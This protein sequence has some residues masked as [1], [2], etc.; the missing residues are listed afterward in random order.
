MMRPMLALD[1]A[2][3]VDSDNET[4]VGSVAT[5]DSVAVAGSAAV[6]GSVAV[7]GSASTAGSVAVAGSVGTAGSV[8]VAGS[9]AT[10]GSVG[11]IASLFTVICVAVRE[12]VACLAMCRLHPVCRVHRVRALYG[13]RRVHRLRELFGTAECSG[14]KEYSR[15]AWRVN[16]RAGGAALWVVGVVGYL[17]LE[18]AAAAAYQPA[19][20]YAQNYIS[21]LGVRGPRTPLM[22]AAFCLQGTMFLLGALFIV[23]VPGDRRGRLFVGLVAANAVGNILVGT[24]HSGMVHIAGAALALA[25][26]NAAILAGSALLAQ[27][28]RWYRYASTV[29]GSLGFLCLALLVAEIRP[30]PVGVWE[31][32]SAY[33]IFLWQLLTAAVLLLRRDDATVKCR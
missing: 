29:I 18:A 3:T 20:S 17:I 26:G 4:V 10:A 8:A 2:I 11:V 28:R 31:R 21:D 7:A 9:A 14:R 13:L 19:Y 15:T 24:V 1:S 30:L 5:I 6:A 22:H 16:R 32:G 27:R 25:G 23:G 33:S 12:C